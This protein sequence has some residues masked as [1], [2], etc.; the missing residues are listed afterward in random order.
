MTNMRIKYFL[1]VFST[2]H[3]AMIKSLHLF[4][5]ILICLTSYSQEVS[6]IDSRHYSNVLGEIRNFRIFLP[7]SYNN[8]SKNYPVIYFFHGWGQRYFGEGSDE[9]AGYDL[10]NQNKGDN[11]A[12]FVAKHEVI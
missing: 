6:I 11:I 8:N 5:F 7:P 9:Y 3:S 2:K 4:L 10:G 1:S 12:N